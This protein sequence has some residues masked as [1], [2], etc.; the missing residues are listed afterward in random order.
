MVGLLFN[1][2]KGDKGE[3]HMA[4]QCTQPTRPRNSSWF[5][6][7]ILMVQAHKSGQVWDE[8][9]LAFLT[10]DLDAYDS[11]C[12][13]ISSAKAVLMANLS[14]YGLDVLFEI[15]PI[16]VIL[17]SIHS[18]DENP[19]RVNIK[20]LYGRTEQMVE[21]GKA[22][23]ETLDAKKDVVMESKKHKD[24]ELNMA[25]CD[26]YIMEEML[27]KLGFV[28]T[29]Y[30]EYGR[31]MVRDLK[32]EIYGFTFLVNFI[33]LEYGDPNQP[34]VMFGRNFLVTTKCQVNFGFGEIDITMLK[35]D[36]DLE[37]LLDNL[38]KHVEEVVGVIVLSY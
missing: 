25:Y 12:D 33:I 20:Q 6:E 38:V 30:G 22:E 21:K 18:D 11:D 10:D 36:R 26:N 2:Y 34:S 29:G 31:K 4:R 35:E 5:K 37:F 3:G 15:F 14:S 24:A 7:K 28:R 16:R 23:L 17:F 13:D 27:E 8:E 9:Q 1:K 32:V 19:S